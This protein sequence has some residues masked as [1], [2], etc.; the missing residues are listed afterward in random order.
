MSR[1]HISR[2]L[3]CC[4]QMVVLNGCWNWMPSYKINIELEINNTTSYDIV[5]QCDNNGSIYTNDLKEISIAGNSEW[6]NSW[7]QYDELKR[8]MFINPE[9]IVLVDGVNYHIEKQMN[10]VNNPCDENNYYCQR[11]MGDSRNVYYHYDYE[12]TDGFIESLKNLS[13]NEEIH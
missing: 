11:E 8:G 10:I 2:L 6:S 5:F 1:K 12:I 7:V 4:L 13:T 3:I 9:M